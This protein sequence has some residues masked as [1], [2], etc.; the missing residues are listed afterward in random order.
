MVGTKI[1]TSADLG[2]DSAEAKAS[3]VHSGIFAGATAAIKKATPEVG[4]RVWALA[5]ERARVGGA[6]VCERTTC[7][8]EQPL[9][10][11]APSPAPVPD[12]TIHVGFAHDSGLK[13]AAAHAC[14]RALTHTHAHARR[15][16]PK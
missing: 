12:A 4:A 10:K 8:R 2:L 7:V 1:T 16:P 11:D 3:Y 15:W 13:V 6:H 14:A 5:C 9:P